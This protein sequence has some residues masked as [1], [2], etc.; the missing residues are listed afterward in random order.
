MTIKKLKITFLILISAC[1][2]LSYAQTVQ[3]STFAGNN[4]WGSNDGTG[5]IARF[6]Q[7]VGV[8]VNSIGNLYVAD[9]Y[10][11]R[12][13]KIISTGA[14]TTLAGNIYGFANGTGA[15]A[16][17]KNPTGIALDGNGNIY[18]ADRNNNCIRKITSAGVVTTLA[19]STTWGYADGI[20]TAAKFKNPTGIAV[21]GNGNIYVTDSENHRIRKITSAGV[22]TTLAGSTW[23]STDG[24]GAV[25]KFDTPTGITIDGIGNLYV[26]DR[27]NH[28]IRK[29][30]STGI[31]TTLAGSTPGFADGNGTVA[32]FSVPTGITV[33]GNG[34]LY[35]TDANNH[36][37]RKIT[38]TGF[39]TTLAGSTPGFADGTGIVAKF[40]NPTGITI[41]GNGNLYVADRY[42]H[43]I[44]KIAICNVPAPTANSVQAICSSAKVSDLT[45]TANTGEIIKWYATAT[46]GTALASTDL[47]TATNYYA[48]AENITTSCVSTTRTMVTITL[49]ASLAAPTADTTQ[50][51]CGSATVADLTATVNSGET[52][53]WYAAATGGTALANADALTATNYFAEAK[54]TTACIS[55]IRTKVAVTLNTLPNAPTANAIQTYCSG[56]TIADL[57]A[58]A[59]TG[60]TIKWYTTTSGGTALANTDVLTT[61]NYYAEAENTSTNCLSA[62]RTT[63]A[64]KINALPNA[65]STNDQT[66]NPGATIADLTT[67]AGTGEVINWY[68]SA[69]GGTPLASN[70][71]LTNATDYYAEAKN[72]STNCISSPRTKI[73]VTITNTSIAE[74]SSGSD[75]QLYPNPTT[76]NITLKTGDNHL[77]YSV[78]DITGKVVITTQQVNNRKTTIQLHHLKQGLYFLTLDNGKEQTIKKIVKQ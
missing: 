29:I 78:T 71:A 49:N 68:S 52:V 33:D 42:N 57:T 67:T 28:R 56:A 13:R 24:T 30:T 72:T 59:G 60:E 39:V 25:A 46:G 11:H 40:N 70:H 51:F 66:H 5:T 9:K 3:V 1:N 36:R 47:L 26:T 17:F 54:N 16:K 7:P 61:A 62:T 15:A 45:A 20:G 53:K 63:V 4:S 10:N 14:V 22:V 23:G 69:T 31:V 43:R 35:V 58:T 38:S 64:V 19:G 2:S 18:V 73:T 37:I 6:N 21:D 34:N 27:N 65:P 50:F 55:A 77:V 8:S 12:I 75:V 76:G 74:N 44:R 41:D 32:K 48:E